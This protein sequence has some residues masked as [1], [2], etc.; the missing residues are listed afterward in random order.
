MRP[1][2]RARFVACPVHLGVRQSSRGG[3]GGQ[4]AVEARAAAPSTSPSS[5]SARGSRAGAGGRAA[6]RSRWCRTR[7]A[8][9]APACLATR[10]SAASTTG[11]RSSG[12]SPTAG[13]ISPSELTQQSAA[14]L[15]ALAVHVARQVRVRPKNSCSSGRSWP[16]AGGSSRFHS[17]TARSGVSTCTAGSVGVD[18]LR[19][20]LEVLLGAVA[21]VPVAGHR[22]HAELACRGSGRPACRA[23]TTTRPS[24][25]V[26]D[27]GQQR[28]SSARPTPRPG[29]R[30][31]DQQLGQLLHRRRSAPRGRSRPARRRPRRHRSGRPAG[32]R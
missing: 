14:G 32:R 15:A 19:A 4:V 23:P 16:I 30:R 12:V 22:H 20:A 2:V 27:S 6:T 8:S 31:R 18:L 3:P 11:T 1:S 17:A 10:S 26:G 5:A 7:R 24:S 28:S 13:P 29:V 21:Q 25:G 9:R